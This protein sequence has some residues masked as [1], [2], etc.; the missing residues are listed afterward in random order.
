MKAIKFPFQID[1]HG[2]VATTDQ[3]PDIVTG[4]LIDVLMTNWNERVQRNRYGANLEAALFDPSDE[5]VRAD[6]SAQVQQRIR[7]FAPR[8]VLKSV[9]FSTDRLRP[10]YI[11]VD[12]IYSAGV[13]DETRTLRLPVSTF[14]S[15]E[16][17]I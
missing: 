6:A 9:E 8:V 14:M 1:I 17:E 11:F 15:Q 4:Q 3:Y 5:L 13:F 16:T 2:S 12:V 10:G 7:G